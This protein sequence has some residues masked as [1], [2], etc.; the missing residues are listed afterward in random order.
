MDDLKLMQIVAF[1]IL[2]EY[3]GGIINK[4]PGYIKEK[5]R[6]IKGYYKDEG[7]I[8]S[9]LDLM[10]SIKFETYKERWLSNNQTNKEND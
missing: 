4:S 7:E 10:N 3:N 5:F 6:L 8:K 9:E 1:C 2:M